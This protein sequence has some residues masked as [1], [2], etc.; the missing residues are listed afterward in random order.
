[1][2]SERC[3]ADHVRCT[4]ETMYEVPAQHTTATLNRTRRY[5][6]TTPTNHLSSAYYTAA[7]TK[8]IRSSGVA[9]WQDRGGGCMQARVPKIVQGKH[10]EVGAAGGS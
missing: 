3:Y 10:S 8:Y 9:D 6:S 4:I 7:C 2:S 1:M 5:P